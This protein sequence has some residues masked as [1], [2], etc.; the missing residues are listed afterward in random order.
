MVR[1]RILLID[2]ATPYREALANVLS[3][4]GHT[5]SVVDLE[6][7]GDVTTGFDGDTVVCDAAILG[8][9]PDL[10][11]RVSSKGARLILIGSLEPG[12]ASS[13]SLDPVVLEKPVN[14]E[15]LRGALRTG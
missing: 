14:M 6:G 5:V 7:S 10:V 3:S 4:D 9:D 1:R 11:N 13:I 15:G 12:P 2:R 8:A